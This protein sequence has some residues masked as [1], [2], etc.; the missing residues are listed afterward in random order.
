MRCYNGCPD[1]ELQ[2]I[3]D[4]EAKATRQLTKRG[5]HATYFPMEGKWMGF[6]LASI[7]VTSFYDTKREMFNSLLQKE[8][9]GSS[10]IFSFCLDLH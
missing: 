8:K 2:A 1:E 9:N 3:I 4:D 10:I 7:S 6:N 5:I